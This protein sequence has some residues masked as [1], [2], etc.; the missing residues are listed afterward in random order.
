[1]IIPLITEHADE[2]AELCRRYQVRKLDVFGSAANGEFN[3]DTS[4]IDFLVT[5]QPDADLGP[6]VC[7]YVEL[8]DELERLLGRPVD[9]VFDK[10]F[11]NPYFRRAVEESRTPFYPTLKDWL[12]APEPRTEQ[13]TPPRRDDSRREPPRFDD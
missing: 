4:D 7:R 10:E 13:L 8:H 11:R 12:L 5:Y 6:W 2:I 9:L 3:P 1:M